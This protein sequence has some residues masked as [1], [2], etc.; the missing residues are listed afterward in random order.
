MSIATIFNWAFNLLVALTFLSM[1][2]ALGQP[3]TFFVFGALSIATFFSYFLVPET[4]GRSLE[5]IEAQMHERGDDHSGTDSG[6][7]RQIMEAVRSAPQ[8]GTLPV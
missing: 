8:P 3:V 5:A 1:L 4:K 2:Q 7:R 6:H